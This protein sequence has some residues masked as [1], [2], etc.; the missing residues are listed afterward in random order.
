M[1]VTSSQFYVFLSCVS[2]GA[3]SGCSIVIFNGF[4]PFIKQ[5]ILKV[6]FDVVCFI[7]I[8]IGYVYYSY[9][10]GFPNFRGYM[11]FGVL[12]GVLLINKSFN[13]I[14]ANCAKKIYN[15]Y[16]RKKRKKHNARKR[17]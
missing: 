11:F 8:S 5:N 9:F 12:L 17:I 1:F 13:F 14:L 7:L 3:I 2:Y 15:I 10:L 4:K 6:I 16:V